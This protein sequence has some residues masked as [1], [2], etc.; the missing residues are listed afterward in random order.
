[1]KCRDEENKLVW[2][3]VTMKSE[4][5]TSQSI[6]AGSVS[7]VM[8]THTRMEDSDWHQWKHKPHIHRSDTDHSLNLSIHLIPTGSLD[9]DQARRWNYLT[10]THT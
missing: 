2:A 1:M 7:G 5:T 4:E 6:L 8:D 3:L 10:H 9:S